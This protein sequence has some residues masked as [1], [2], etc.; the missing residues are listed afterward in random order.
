[1]KLQAL[2]CAILSAAACLNAQEILVSRR[3]YA[4]HRRT[5][6]QI[7]AAS[8]GTLDFKQLTETPRDHMEPLCSRDGKL[9][10]F[11]S[12]HQAQR[13]ANAYAGANDRELWAFD[14][15]TGQE[16][17]VWQTSGNDGLHLNGATADAGVLIRT[18]TGLQ[19]LLRHPWRIDKIDPQVSA[20]A[21]SPDGRTL[22]I[23]VAE[24]LDK[25]GQSNGSKL[26][27]VDTR[28]GQPRTQL[29]KYD[30]P[31]WSLDGARIAA[32]ATDAP[33][34][35]AII[36]AAV[37]NEAARVPWP[38]SDRLPENLVWSPDGKA[39]LAGLYGEN[40]GSGDP[41]RDY[42][43]LNIAARAW[44][45]VITAQTLLWLKTGSLLYL[46]PVATAPLTPG[47]SHSVWTAQLA[48]FDLSTK[49]DTQLTTGLVLNDY[50]SSCGR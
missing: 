30:A 50:L 40:G 12:D 15:Q 32:I 14:R 10:Y 19:C 37:R 42:Y 34:G 11:V 44:T 35:L 27:L 8:S 36:D 29:G 38:R 7:W 23:V 22:A 46:R 48:V 45:R 4:S 1:M 21:V 43:L 31:A 6:R 2:S 24:S 49:K 47:S 5:W 18:G 41:Q 26:F 39:I 3:E 16:R 28:D 33:A 20:A 13:S 25:D 9:I 17:M